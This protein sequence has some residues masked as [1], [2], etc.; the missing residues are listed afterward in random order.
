MWLQ[1]QVF[2]YWAVLP[3]SWSI[4]DV[5]AWLSDWFDWGKDWLMDK[6]SKRKWKEED[7]GKCDAVRWRDLFAARDK[8]GRQEE[9]RAV[10]GRGDRGSSPL[11][12]QCVFWGWTECLCM[13]NLTG[14]QQEGRCELYSLCVCV[15]VCVW[16][17]ACVCSE[18]RPTSDPRA[19]H[20]PPSAAQESAF[21]SFCAQRV[22]VWVCVRACGSCDVDRVGLNSPKGRHRQQWIGS[23]RL[24]FLL[25]EWLENPRG[26]TGFGSRTTHLPSA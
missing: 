24:E 6:E 2:L 21:C 10:G 3:V 7:R 19:A 16:S 18:T 26:F 12:Q 14:H 22:C 5:V 25:V 11:G 23:K 8:E 4:K 17:C 20:T 1:C 13:Q 9:E 15:Y